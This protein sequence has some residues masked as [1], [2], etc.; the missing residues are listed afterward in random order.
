M[1]C[2]AALAAAFGVLAPLAAA[3]A[4]VITVGPG[5]QF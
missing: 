1:K 4:S 3:Q 2:Q 5:G